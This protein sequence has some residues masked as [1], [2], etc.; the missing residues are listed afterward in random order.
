ME[1]DND[2]EIENNHEGADLWG[3]GAY[4]KTFDINDP[5][6]QERMKYF[7]EKSDEKKEYNCKKC[8]KQI[9]K[10]NLYWHEGMCNDCFFNAYDL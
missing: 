3:E 7:E 9:G 2:E 8:N 4:A 6:L 5:N 10:H 1:N